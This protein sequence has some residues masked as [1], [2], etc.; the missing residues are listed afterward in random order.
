[1]SFSLS[2]GV[3]VIEKDFTTI[4]PAVSSSVGAF[5]GAFAWG[6]VLDPQLIS[7]ENDL[8]SVF[9]K[10]NIKNYTSFF[11]AS[12]FLAYTNSLFV[13]R[14]DSIARTACAEP[15]GSVVDVTLGTQSAIYNAGYT[16]TF[17][18]SPN[19]ETATASIVLSGT[20]VVSCAMATNGSG[21]DGVPRIVLSGGGGG[22]GCVL[23]AVVSGGDHHV[24][25]ITIDNPGSGYTVAP[26]L[27]FQTNGAGMG[28]AAT[29]TLT[30]GAVTGFN[31]SQAGSGYYATTATVTVSGGGGTNASFTAN[32]SSGTIASLTPTAPGSGYTS[33]P[34]VTITGAGFGATANLAVLADTTINHFIIVNPGSGYRETPILTVKDAGGNVVTQPE[35]TVNAKFEGVTGLH[36]Q[37]SYHTSFS[38]GT[39]VYGEFAAKWPGSL[40]NC[41]GVSCAD[42]HSFDQL[43]DGLNPAPWEFHNEFDR[44]PG[45]SAYAAGVSGSDDEMHIVVIDRTGA[46]T[47]APGTIL[48]KFAF[49]SK[50]VDAK[51]PDGTNNYYVDVLNE[52]SKYIWWLDHPVAG[53]MVGGLTPNWGQPALST[54]FTKLNVEFTYQFSG[55]TNGNTINTEFLLNDQNQQAAYELYQNAEQY[56]VSLIVCGKMTALSAK[57]IIENVCEIRKDCVAFCSPQHSAAMGSG[58]IIGNSSEEIFD[59]IGYRTGFD[60]G[61]ANDEGPLPSSS[62]GVC[63]SGYKYQ[64]DRYN[65]KYWWIPLNGDVAG[66]CARTDY[67]NDP[68]F[69]PGGFN[70]GQI[71][72]VVKLAHNPNKAAR[73]QLYKNS[74]NPVVS[75]PGQGV[76]LYGD[77]TL[78]DKPSAFDRINV[79]RLFIVLEKAIAAA[80][81]YSLFELNDTFTRAQFKSMVEPFLRDVQGRRGIYEF[82]VVCDERNNSGEIIDRN[83]FAGDIYIKPAKSINFINLSFIAAR[84]AVSFSELGA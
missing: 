29:V 26:T 40:G 80:A 46:L 71:K 81:K 54:N 78:L 10:P 28:A 44:A 8:V 9:G 11:S 61:V 4:I 42:V 14:V 77:K 48:E 68:W 83:E 37:Q 49:V 13:T 1:M 35:M 5:A 30:N 53:D 82:R 3:N 17:N 59:V 41:I 6:P 38:T 62:Y 43:M 66:L 15:S 55:G 52:R 31:I 27:T 19:G 72:N 76:I 12:N 18:T 74:V 64:Y 21:Y 50:A 58:P 39:L 45:T 32:I 70:R 63:D 20:T 73:D 22:Q 56:D 7:S 65:D 75:F 34:T 2:A 23:T 57:W 33:R 60:N 36:N 47:G 25:S 69:S 51:L 24:S 79:R 84:T 67:T 16:A